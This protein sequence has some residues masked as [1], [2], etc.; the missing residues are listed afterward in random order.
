MNQNN[1]EKMETFVRRL[2]VGCFFGF[3]F[4]FGFT[5]SAALAFATLFLVFVV[6]TLLYD[7]HLS[8]KER[9]ANPNYYEDEKLEKGYQDWLEQQ[10]HDIK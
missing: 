2:G 6:S 10:R 9:L 3:F 8:Q 7:C 1:N 4:L 5:E